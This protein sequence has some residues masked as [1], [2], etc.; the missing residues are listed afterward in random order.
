MK[1][2]IF[3][4]ETRW[5]VPHPLIH[6]WNQVGLVSKYPT[7]WKGIER[8][9]LLQG[10]EL[11]IS[12]GSKA[13][14]TVASPLY[15]L[16][17]QTETIEFDM[18]K[19]I[20]ARATGDLDG[21]GKWIF[22]HNDHTTHATFIWEVALTP[23]FLHAVSHLPGARSI[24]EFFHDRLMAQGEQGLRELLAKHNS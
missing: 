4:F 20:L 13:A 3:R 18:G 12:V 1:D 11:P 9:D 10:P 6:V 19:Y 7:W 17:Y 21:T 8:V 24:M 2:E 5:S 15:T 14:Y 23:P 22:E 16:H